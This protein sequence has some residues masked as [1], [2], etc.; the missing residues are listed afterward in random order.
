MRWPG[1][2][3]SFPAGC[4]SWEGGDWGAQPRFPSRT[5]RPRAGGAVLVGRT[6]GA[7]AQRVQ[8]LFAPPANICPSCQRAGSQL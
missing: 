8:R 5:S 1:A 4:W 7:M 6:P 2:G 3:P